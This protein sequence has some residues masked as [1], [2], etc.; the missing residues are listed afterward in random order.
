MEDGSVVI[1]ILGDRKHIAKELEATR[2]DIEKTEKKLAEK[3]SEKSGIESKLED[4]MNAAKATS[5]KI[6]ALK[7]E[8][9][10][11]GAVMG[12][13][14]TSAADYG[15]A[16][17]RQAAITKELQMQQPILKAQDADADKLHSRYEAVSAEVEHLTT[18]LETAKGKAEDLT[19]QEEQAKAGE[20]VRKQLDRAS[21]SAE[22][23]QKRMLR[24][25]RSALVYNLI[26]SALRSAVSYFGKLL[27]TNQ[28]Y[29][30][31]LAKLQGALLTAFQ[32]LAAQIIPWAVSLLRILTSVVQVVGNLLSLLFGGTLL[33]SAKSAEALNKQASAISGVGAAAK[34]AEK[35][36]ASFDQINK[37]NSNKDSGGGG[38]GGG[39]V[40]PDFSDFDKFQTEEYQRELNRL[41][42]ILS[43]SLL[44][45]GAILFF[46]GTNIPLG[47]GLMAAGAIGLANIAS[48]KWGEVTDDLRATLTKI[49]GI[50][51]TSFLVIGAIL[52]FFCGGPINIARGIA[53]LALGAATL[54]GMAYINRDYIPKELQ[55]IAIAVC[56]IGGVI[57]T[58]V[59]I[60]MLFICPAK[61]GLAI[62]LIL[63][64]L[65][66][67]STAVALDGAFNETSLKESASSICK[68]GGVIMVAVGIIILF[69]VPGKT[70]LA[71]G[72]ILLGGAL[73]GTAES[74]D[75][76][77]MELSLKETATGI[78]KVGG[79]ILTAVGVAL[80]F[81][82]AD[83]HHKAIGIG[84]IVAGAVFLGTAAVLN[85]DS[86][87]GELGAAAYGICKMGGAVMF[88]IGAALLFSGANIPLG[89]G[90]L[91][92]GYE[93]VKLANA[94]PWND[95]A[96]KESLTSTFQEILAAGE[97]LLVAAGLVLLFSGAN[98]PLG[99]G[100][101]A[102]GGAALW[103]DH[104]LGYDD[105]EILRMTQETEAKLSN[106]VADA[107]KKGT[108]VFEFA[109]STMNDAI[110][111]GISGEVLYQSLAGLQLSD[112]DMRALGFKVIGS[113]ADAFIAGLVAGLEDYD[114]TVSDVL[115][116]SMARSI[117]E[118]ALKM[119]AGEL[120]SEGA[121]KQLNSRIQSLLESG[122]LTEDEIADIMNSEAITDTL[123]RMG[124]SF[125]DGYIQGMDKEKAAQA[126]GD[127]TQ[128]ALD[129]I[130][131][132]QDSHSPA[133]KTEALGKDA[134]VG[135]V[136]GVVNNAA[137][138]K[139]AGQTMVESLVNGMASRTSLLDAV[140]N[141]IVDAANS[142][143][144]SV[145]AAAN[146]AVEAMTSVS[147]S[148]GTVRI[149][150]PAL[151]ALSIPTLPKLATGAV[152]P[153]NAPFAAILGDQ[154]SGTNVETPLATIQQA[155]SDVVKGNDMIS[156][157][158]EQNRLLQQILERCDIKLDGRSIA[159][160][161]NTYQRQ[162]SRAS[163]GDGYGII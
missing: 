75:S 133:K 158:K 96:A 15:R 10:E 57:M 33:G 161:V 58:A 73:L 1:S 162:M 152:I 8:Y 21:A 74:L 42:A 95:Q 25:A 3:V 155:V 97:V 47:L 144:S 100:L 84:L 94:I 135:Y 83:P 40:S 127:M 156:A 76:G 70:A 111:N 81:A 131:D 105:S 93:A 89:L 119:D 91:V 87:Q 118:A 143:A 43:G 116:K 13:K 11:L 106:Q 23:F 123:S 120:T 45:L 132:T 34:E 66:L 72:M 29:R 142:M 14:N 64:G 24:I 67:A 65:V 114:T 98:I 51:S 28:E 124:L 128:S 122:M 38:G 157:L 130:A 69:N 46:T 90:L 126:A 115:S 52:T 108:T 103:A 44:A 71:I 101:L 153:P 104:M 63:A 32:P 31:E 85:W 4:A 77:S 6:R 37:L 139:A 36:L 61:A 78:L 5:E 136:N 62:S 53:L 146:A 49:F 30:A 121:A 138:V 88:A 145:V 60:V 159:E 141:H 68:L 107:K 113:G 17:S 48:G 86:L 148:G 110:D 117:N 147:Y 7:R 9:R 134:V 35:Q 50:L 82:S 59:G 140:L 151:R 102:A 54:V 18:A 154:R 109:Q 129:A 160:T 16:A 99:L 20:A 150:A 22:R 55:D 92:S 125:T 19:N 149:P 112:D 137:A 2:K 79:V 26:S 56:A 41:T 80:L 39:G 12:D 163:G 27:N